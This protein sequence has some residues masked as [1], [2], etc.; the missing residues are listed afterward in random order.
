MKKSALQKEPNF[1]SRAI[2]KILSLPPLLWVIVLIFVFFG[3][4]APRF[5]NLS[6]FINVL[7]QGAFLW[8]LS[9]VTTLVLISGGLDLSL[10]SIV[11]ISGVVMALLLKA[12]QPAIVA[13]LGGVMCGVIV[14][15]ING[16]VISIIGIPAFIATL[17]TMNVFGGLA[18]VL[19]KASAIY[20]GD[21]TMVFLGAGAIAG[22]PMPVIIAVLVFGVSY[23][24]LHHTSFG[25]YL[26]AL[27][28]NSAGALLSGVKTKKNF[29]LVY[30]YAGMIAG[31]AGVMLASRL[32]SADPIVGIGLEFDAIAAAILG[33]TIGEKG[34]GSITTTI[35]GVGTIVF[36]RNG[37]NII[38]IPAIW[39]SAVVGTFLLFA[40]V[41]DVSI[42]RRETN[43]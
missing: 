17:G 40:I 14:G 28:G 32:Q 43:Q 2:K 3:F 33:G 41:F 16:F 29:W 4:A 22:I 12:G 24:L 37:L 10:G 21:P 30:V 7:R 42:R 15:A 9:T 27:G 36:L 13:I 20:V 25:R 35:I 39:Q 31:I 23:V 8:M 5:F 34:K 38:G 1:G 26:V 19:T 11:T 6:N 18:L